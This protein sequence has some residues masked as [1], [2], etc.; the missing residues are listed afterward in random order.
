MGRGG[1]IEERVEGRKKVKG[2]QDKWGGWLWRTLCLSMCRMSDVSMY[3]N[4]SSVCPPSISSTSK[5]KVA[6]TSRVCSKDS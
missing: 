4:P 6:V 2:Q 1:E 5:R 3:F